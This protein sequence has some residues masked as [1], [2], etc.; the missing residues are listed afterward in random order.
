MEHSDLIKRNLGP[1]IQIPQDI[2]LRL[3]MSILGLLYA[4]KDD[5]TKIEW[6]KIVELKYHSHADR[7]RQGTPSL[8]PA[9]MFE[10]WKMLKIYHSR[11]LNLV[12]QR[13]LLHYCVKNTCLEDVIGHSCDLS[14]WSCKVH[15]VRFRPI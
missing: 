9:V 14:C 2:A 5:G 11:S 13:L 3:H 6:Y 15:P 4:P 12:Y 1:T 7:V 10:K 8:F